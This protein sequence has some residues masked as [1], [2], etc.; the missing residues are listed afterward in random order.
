MSFNLS[1]MARRVFSVVSQSMQASVTETP[2]SMLS[3]IFL[4]SPA[5]IALYHQ[6]NNGLIAFYN[7]IGDIFQNQ[8]LQTGVFV[9]VG[10]GA[11]HHY[12]GFDTGFMQFLFT[13]S[14]TD[15]VIIWL[16]AS[17]TKN[18]VTIRITPWF[19]SLLPDHCRL[20]LESGGVLIP[21]S[22]H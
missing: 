13:D 16:A 2:Y 18:Y 12:I 19:G 5:N 4:G 15:G 9:R 14:H 6:A 3:L 21:S 11:V 7:L 17:T 10:M 22:V 1:C 20:Y 8:G